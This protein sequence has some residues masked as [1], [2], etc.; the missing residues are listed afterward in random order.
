MNRQQRDTGDNWQVAAARLV[1]TDR[2]Q[3]ETIDRHTAML[4]KLVLLGPAIEM[5]QRG[6]TDLKQDFEAQCNAVKADVAT[7]F[8]HL[9]ETAKEAARFRVQRLSLYL[10]GCAVIATIL[11]VAVT[12]LKAIGK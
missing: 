5:I 8:D 2:H 10:S 3:Q 9:E 7:R 1:E 12:I 4:D 11:G 6:M